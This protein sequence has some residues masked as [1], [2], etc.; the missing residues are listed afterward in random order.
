[1]TQLAASKYLHDSGEEERVFNDEW[2]ASAELEL[3]ELNLAERDF[4]TAM[5]GPYLRRPS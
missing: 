5:V 1:M 3:S 4:L 2:A